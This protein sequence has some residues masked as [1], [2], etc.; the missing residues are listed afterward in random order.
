MTVRTPL[1]T[2]SLG[3][4]PSN[5]WDL[6]TWQMVKGSSDWCWKAAQPS[7]R[8]VLC[9]SVPQYIFH[10]VRATVTGLPDSEFSTVE[11]RP[12]GQLL[13]TWTWRVVPTEVL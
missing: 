3:P 1:C 11:A 10:R 13:T 2:Q 5:K 12:T 8:P 6:H 9:Y 7:L 4:A